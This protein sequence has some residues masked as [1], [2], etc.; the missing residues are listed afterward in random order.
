[1]GW[2]YLL[3]HF[4]GVVAVFSYE[5][6]TVWWTNTPH[7]RFRF[8]EGCR[9]CLWRMDQDTERSLQ[10]RG[11][12]VGVRCNEK[13]MRVGA[14]ELLAVNVGGALLVLKRGK[15]LSTLS[16]AISLQSPAP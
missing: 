5:N 10:D 13:R 9:S 12:D 1:M 3:D 11:F 8:S 7:G 2:R 4:G 15:A 14:A 6:S 16:G